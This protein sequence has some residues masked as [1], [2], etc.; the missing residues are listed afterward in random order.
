MPSRNL[1]A[2]ALNNYPLH[3]PQSSMGGVID[4]SVNRRGG[5]APQARSPAAPGFGQSQTSASDGAFSDES[6]TTSARYSRGSMAPRARRVASSPAASAAEGSARRKATIAQLAGRRKFEVGDVYTPID[7]SARERDKYPTIE[8]PPM[9]DVFD[10]LG[11]NPLDEYKVSL[12]LPS[13][14]DEVSPYQQLWTAPVYLT[15]R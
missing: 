10:A 12:S 2:T 8:K 15:H 6:G 13:Q 11:I 3:S 9:R 4:R 7:L 14:S 5:F 1:S